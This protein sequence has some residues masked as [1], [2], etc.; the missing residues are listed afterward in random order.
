MG[1][2]WHCVRPALFALPPERAHHL[3]IYALKTL[4]VRGRGGRGREFADARLRLRLGGMEFPNPLGLAAGFDKNGEV[5]DALLRLGFGHVEIGTLTPLPQLGNPRPR[6]FRLSQDQALINRMGFNNQGHGALLQRLEQRSNKHKG[7]EGGREG[8]IGLNIGANK[9]SAD[10]L[11]DYASAITLFHDKVDYFT[12][13]VSSPNTPGL[14]DLQNRENLDE[15]L[16]QSQ[17]ARAAN[18]EEGKLAPPI[19]LKIAPD[20]SEAQLDDIAAIVLERK[21]DGLVI[22]NTS[23][24]R[25]D[26]VSG[27]AYQ[28]GGLS[29]RPLFD[30]ATIILAKMRQRVGKNLPIIGVGGID[31][32]QRA[33]EKICAGADLLQ[34]YSAM[35]FAGPA[36]A[37][38]ILHQLAAIC[39]RDGVKHISE[40]R[41]QHVGQWASLPI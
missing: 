26:L 6:L 31:S 25:P 18:M 38:Q 41:D 34:L 3:A 29:G 12:I 11:A 8:I 35:I 36:I 2:L 7:R 1:L 21:C 22:S 20:L 9:D 32:G 10:R 19:F 39:D 17:Q 23:L 24:A 5:P 30:R 4:W 27:Q 16:K 13:N 37:M 40:Y 33:W 15:L 28:S 14:R